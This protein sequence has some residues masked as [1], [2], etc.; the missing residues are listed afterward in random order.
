MLFY[1]AALG[2]KN[3]CGAANFTANH[4][5]CYP[6]ILLYYRERNP[7]ICAK[8]FYYRVFMKSQAPRAAIENFMKIDGIWISRI[9]ARQFLYTISHDYTLAVLGENLELELESE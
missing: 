1:K 5:I 8:F 6:F 9:N 3:A 7:T 2:L 4:Y